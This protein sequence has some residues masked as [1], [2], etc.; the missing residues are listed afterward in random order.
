MPGSAKINPTF[1]YLCANGMGTWTAILRGEVDIRN[2]CG[3][4]KCFQ[5]M[6]ENRTWQNI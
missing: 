5:G 2:R 6:R 4:S 3:G 1:S